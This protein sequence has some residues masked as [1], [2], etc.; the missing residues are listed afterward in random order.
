MNINLDDLREAILR[1]A[2]KDS[3]DGMPLT[4]YDLI[5]IIDFLKKIEREKK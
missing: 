3:T 5:Q 2:A 4:P 1:A